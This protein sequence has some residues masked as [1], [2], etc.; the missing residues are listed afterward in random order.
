MNNLEPSFILGEK[1]FSTQL[2]MIKCHNCK[3]TRHHSI[4]SKCA[5]CK[6]HV[7]DFCIHQGKYIEQYDKAI[8][9][10]TI[11]IFFPDISHYQTIYT[12]K[13]YYICSFKCEVEFFLQYLETTSLLPPT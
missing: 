2:S 8:E 3:K 5:I 13:V 9:T 11:K 6:E 1:K 10:I 7:C 4:F 12:E